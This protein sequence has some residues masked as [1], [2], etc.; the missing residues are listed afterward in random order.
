MAAG[1]A[2]PWISALAFAGS[3]LALALAA[4]LGG[5]LAALN[6]TSRQART[7]IAEQRDDEVRQSLQ[8]LA[9]DARS[10]VDETRRIV[11]DLRAAE[12]LD[13][14]RAARALLTHA[15]GSTAGSA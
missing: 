12:A 8:T 9:T 2:W 6:R 1:L 5:R 13:E 15:D 4:A 3:L 14:L 7:L 11:T 10:A